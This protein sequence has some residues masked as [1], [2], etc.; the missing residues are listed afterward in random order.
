MGF[1]GGH[2]GSAPSPFDAINGPRL[3]GGEG[4]HP[5]HSVSPEELLNPSDG[6]VTGE[7]VLDQ[8]ARVG[9]GITGHV[10]LTAAKEVNARKAYLRLVGLRL[11]EVRREVD[12]RDS[13]GN[14]DVHRAVGRNG[15]QALQRGCLP[16]AADPDQP[17]AGRDLGVDLRG[18]GA[19]AWPAH[20]SSGR[21]DHRLGA[22]GPLG[23]RHGLRSL[24]R[25]VPAPGPAPGP[26]SRRGRQ[27][28]RHEPD[29]RRA[30][31]RRDDQ[32]D[33]APAGARRSGSGRHGV[34]ALG[35]VRAGSPH[36]D[37][38]PHELPSNTMVEAT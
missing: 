24:G 17:R 13:K 31:G 27:A 9:D 4:S 11:D 19:T 33:L 18:S 36:R 29:G 22:R 37:P 6:A 15:G 30:R 5:L 8:P 2:T 25:P 16:G 10:R 3:A 26:S 32:R 12:H 38:P 7:F 34:V 35:T 14:V 20:G 1:F 21:V 23:H 28:G